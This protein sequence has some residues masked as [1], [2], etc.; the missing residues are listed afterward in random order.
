L[1]TILHRA[2]DRGIG[3]LYTFFKVCYT[4]QSALLSDRFL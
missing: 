3:E 4:E 1:E 2:D